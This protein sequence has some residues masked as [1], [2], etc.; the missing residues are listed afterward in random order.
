M[1]LNRLEFVLMNNGLRNIIQEKYELKI[2]RKLSSTQNINRA[3]E[4]GCGNGNGSKLIK[5]YFKPKELISIDLDKRMIKRASE[6]NNDQSISFKVMDA[7]D[8]NFSDN[9]FDAI[10]DFGIIHHIPNWKVCLTELRRVLKSNGELIMED[11][12]IDSFSTGFGKLL[13][14]ILDHP[15]D[16]M[17][18]NIQF[19]DELKNQG[20]KILNYLELNP[21]G[22]I[23]HFS[24]NATIN[25]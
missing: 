18:S 14:I 8:L 16:Q 1:K 22:L 19:T 11:L 24:L 5:K 15:Y 13:K 23:K 10:F 3:L 9:Y 4:I 17:Y 6:K 20:F 2:L 25:K 21:L 7:S 12:S